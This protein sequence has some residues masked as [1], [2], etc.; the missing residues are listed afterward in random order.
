[1]NVADKELCKELYEL[2]EF[3]G[4]YW[5]YC[6]IDP[7]NWQL[8]TD[9]E[10][11][12]DSTKNN[13]PWCPAYELDY[14]LRKLPLTAKHPATGEKHTL[15]LSWHLTKKKWI[16]DYERSM[17]AHAFADTPENATAKLAIILFKQGIL[18]KEPNTHE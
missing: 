6:E 3:T 12:L 15:G 14:L 16:A 17:I 13:Q 11:Y 8:C 7:G 1:M 5:K 9:S 4:T 10:K 18:L 2:S